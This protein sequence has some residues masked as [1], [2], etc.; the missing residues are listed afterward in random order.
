MNE[1]YIHCSVLFC[2]RIVEENEPQAGAPNAADEVPL[3][4]PGV[5]VLEGIY[6]PERRLI[7]AKASKVKRNIGKELGPV[8]IQTAFVGKQMSTYNIT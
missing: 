1:F 4:A 3:G 2:T 7:L 6:Q 8:R 5:S